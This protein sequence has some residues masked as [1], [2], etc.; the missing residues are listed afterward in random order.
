[1]ITLIKTLFKMKQ[2]A[3]Q[4]TTAQTIIEMLTNGMQETLVVFDTLLQVKPTPHFLL[5]EISAV[6]VDGNERLW[7]KT[8][9]DSW[10]SLSDHLIYQDHILNSL[11]QRLAPM[12]K[13][14]IS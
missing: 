2:T 12:L 5:M 8:G 7:V 13:T 9:R 14:N 11:Y 1:M 10:M 6:E 4:K 3:T